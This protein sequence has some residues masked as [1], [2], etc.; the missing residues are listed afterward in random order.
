MGGIAA[1]STEIYIV[2][3]A[4]PQTMIGGEAQDTPVTLVITDNANPE[5]T[6]TLPNA[7]LLK[8]AVELT[9]EISGSG[10]VTL[11]PASLEGGTSGGLYLRNAPIQAT[12]APA[13]GFEV[14]QVI[15][16][17]ADATGEVANNTLN[18]TIA[19]PGAW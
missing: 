14:S 3:P 9:V 4:L 19:E 6:V 17:D 5:N 12:F 16:N 15:L 11:S 8:S 10:S 18:F 13:A 7:A 1:T 2:T